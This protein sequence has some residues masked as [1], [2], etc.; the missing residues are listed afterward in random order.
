[1]EHH[2]AIVLAHGDPVAA[3]SVTLPG[4][5]LVIAA[6]GGLSLAAALG[7]T[8]DVVVGDMDSVNPQDLERA[9][10]SG[11]RI[12]VHPVDKDETDLELALA[13]ALAAGAVDITIV[14]GVGGRLDHLLAN[15]M[16][17]SAASAD[18]LTMRWLTGSEE[19]LPCFPNRPVGIDGHPGDLVSL[20]PI[21]GPVRGVRTSGLRWQLDGDELGRGST[22]GV[23]NEMTAS[24]AQVWVDDGGL[25]VVHTR[26]G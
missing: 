15:T 24:E 18:G 26:N 5:A 14:G 22:R 17:L 6:D 25:L 13:V 19:V 23:S 7:L 12:D 20:I 21:D 3:G 1:V 11:A 16:L 2:R 9:E 8:P 10:R 4:D